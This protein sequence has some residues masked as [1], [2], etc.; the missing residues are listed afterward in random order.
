MARMERVAK[1]QLAAC[2]VKETRIGKLK[3]RV[4]VVEHA[5]QLISKDN[6]PWVQGRKGENYK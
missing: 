5:R 1:S 3:S 6:R 4:V 2:R